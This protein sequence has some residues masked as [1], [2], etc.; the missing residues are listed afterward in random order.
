[1]TVTGAGVHLSH[2]LAREFL[3]EALKAA[4]VSSL[5]SIYFAPS[6]KYQ[7]IIMQFL[8]KPDLLF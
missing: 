6:T 3:N 5:C 1:M 2:G 8:R 4:M 7:Y